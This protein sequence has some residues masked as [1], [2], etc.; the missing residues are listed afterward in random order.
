M[1]SKSETWWNLPLTNFMQVERNKE[2]GE[3]GDEEIF[4][5]V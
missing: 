1:T 5:L 4:N 2:Q 3:E